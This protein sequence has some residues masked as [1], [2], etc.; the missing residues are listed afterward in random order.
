[1][2]AVFNTDNEGIAEARARILEKKKV[3]ILPVSH[4]NCWDDCDSDSADSDDDGDC[5]CEWPL[6]VSMIL[7]GRAGN[8]ETGFLPFAFFEEQKNVCFI[9]TMN[10]KYYILNP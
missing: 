9:L 6:R 4:R 3:I 10:E 5:F 2:A 8:R 1:M 7:N